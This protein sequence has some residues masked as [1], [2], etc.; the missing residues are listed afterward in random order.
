MASADTPLYGLVLAGGR[1]RRMGRD[2]ALLRREGKSQ[3]EH[4]YALLDTVADKTFVSTRQGQEEDSERS[5]FPQLV[6]LYE[7]LGP[8]AGILTALETFPSADWLVLACDLP[9]VDRK[10]IDRLLEGRTSG[11][12][13]VA[14][15]S[16]HDELPE[17]LCA[18]YPAGS[19]ELVR[20]F[21]DSGVNCPRKIMI[22]AGA[23]LLEQPDPSALDNINTPD[24]L[25]D[26]V[27]EAQR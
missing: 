8:V 13:L 5:R 7:D 9:N 15:R 4:A 21:V 26:S 14:F 11:G 6:D 22:R 1:S 27:L 24:D 2:K 12:D 25:E 19:A 23:R 20:G 16:S 10:T 17:P 3:L 18:I